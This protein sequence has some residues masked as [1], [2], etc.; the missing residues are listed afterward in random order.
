MCDGPEASPLQVQEGLLREVAPRCVPPREDAERD[1]LPLPDDEEASSSVTQLYQIEL[2][3]RISGVPPTSGFRPAPGREDIDSAMRNRFYS[4][5]ARPGHY[6]FVTRDM[7]PA[8][9]LSGRPRGIRG[10]GDLCDDEGAALGV[11]IASAIMRVGGSLVESTGRSTVDSEGAKTGGDTGRA[12]AGRTLTSG[13][14]ALVDAWT[15]SCL[16]ATRGASTGASPSESID[17]ALARARAELAAT[18]ASRDTEALELEH[19][20]MDREDAR[21][22]TT[23]NWIIG[24]V[25]AVV[26]LGGA[27]VFLK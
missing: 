24:G 11:G 12:T 14:D 5:V 17:S 10:L 21:A 19:E 9:Q 27:Y 6:G 18:T 7:V 1:A 15:N 16:S 20:R 23:R 2:P 13:G 25:A 22:A 4:D 8:G 3:G 26:V